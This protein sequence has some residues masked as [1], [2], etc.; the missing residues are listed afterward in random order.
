MLGIHTHT[1]ALYSNVIRMILSED[2]EIPRMTKY[3]YNDDD[4]EILSVGRSFHTFLMNFACPE[5]GHGVPGC[6]S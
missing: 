6:L 1:D 5:C 3:H 2:V 4:W